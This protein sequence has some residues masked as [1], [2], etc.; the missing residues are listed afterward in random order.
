MHANTYIRIE[1]IPTYIHAH[2]CT[3]IQSYILTYFGILIHIC[4][5]TYIHSILA[6]MHTDVYVCMHN[7]WGKL[8]GGNVL[9]K[10]GG[11]IVWGEYPGGIVLHPSI[12]FY[13]LLNSAA[14]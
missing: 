14:T 4:I 12:S 3:Y 10:T 1:Y 5:H 2:I 9:P 13:I 7:I 11:G 6:C 8:S